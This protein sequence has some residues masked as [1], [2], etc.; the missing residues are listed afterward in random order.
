MSG[1]PTRRRAEIR[2]GEIARRQ[3]GV[4]SRAQ[5]LAAGMTRDMIDY[6]VS[7][8]RWEL[9]FRGVY[10]IRGVPPSLPQQTLAACLFAG[11]GSFAVA[12]TAA[13]AWG[14]EGGRWNPP[15]IAAERHPSHLDGRLTVHRCLSYLRSD[16]TSV[17]PLP[18]TTVTR[19]LVDLA[20]RLDD[21]TLELALDQA[22]R[23][24]RASVPGLADRLS[25]LAASRLAGLPR[26]RKLIT[27]RDPDAVIKPTELETL[28]RRWLRQFQFPDPIFQY[29]VQLP[30]YGSSR[31]DFAYPDL[32]VGVEADSYAFHTGREA[33]ERDRVRLSE[34]ASLG[35]IIIQT[36]SREIELQPDRPAR[37]LR[38]A[39]DQRL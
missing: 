26:L 33:F 2:C 8:G 29:H 15:E 27:E 20:K 23:S 38:R 4:I 3:Y 13:A 35:W 10:R 37:R 28:V 6:R 21:R 7:T 9:L 31:L 30:D 32:L 19:T 34:Y 11:P 18:L 5:A 14:L 24:G 16:V 36:T 17:G 1:Q 12:T 25:N 39:L 22:L